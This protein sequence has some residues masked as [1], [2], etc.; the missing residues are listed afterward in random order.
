MLLAPTTEIDIVPLRF[1]RRRAQRGK[2]RAR[3]PG[4]PGSLSVPFLAQIEVFA[5]N[6]VLVDYCS[7]FGFE[8]VVAK[9]PNSAHASK[10]S[11]RWVKAKCSNGKRANAKGWRVFETEGG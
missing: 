7:R 8:G 2:G 9:Q 6:A 1:G 11:R 4:S 10:S 3:R 5:D